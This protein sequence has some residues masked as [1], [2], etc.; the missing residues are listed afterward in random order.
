MCFSNLGSARNNYDLR[1]N[2]SFLFLFFFSFIQYLSYN[3]ILY[4][5]LSFLIALSLSLFY[6]SKWY[7]TLSL[8]LCS[9]ST[10]SL[11][12][13]VFLSLF[14]SLSVYFNLSHDTLSFSH[15]FFFISRNEYAKVLLS[16]AN[17]NPK[18]FACLDA[19]LSVCLCP[20]QAKQSQVGAIQW[21]L[22]QVWSIEE[23]ERQ[24]RKRREEKRATKQTTKK[25]NK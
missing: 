2:L 14:L 25:E 5:Y 11:V 15:S 20:W 16:L 7:V 17:P 3:H 10:L 8:S 22:G 12:L 23:R 18:Y 6:L 4:L 9:Y 21:R 19:L 24:T 1:T 13:F